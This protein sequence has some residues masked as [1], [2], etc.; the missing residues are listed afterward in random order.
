MKTVISCV[1][2][3]V[4]ASAS[5]GYRA[6]SVESLIKQLKDKDDVVRLKAA[7]ELGKLGAAAKDAIPALTEALKDPDDD[8]R[9]VAKNSLALIREAVEPAE[10]KERKKRAREKLEPLLKDLRG[11]PKDLRRAQT[12][13][14][15]ALKKIA[16]LGADG[17]EASEAIIELCADNVPAIREAAFD[18]LQKVN[19]TLH[20]P[21]IALLIDR[22]DAKKLAAI[23]ELGKL[24]AEAKP[25]IPLLIQFY[26]LRALM[27]RS[28]GFGSY[29]SVP[30]LSALNSIDA[31]NKRF[32]RLLLA[33][34]PVTP[35]SKPGVVFVDWAPRKKAIELTLE[36]VEAKR[37]KARDAVKPFLSA[38]SDP[39]CKIQ[40]IKALGELGVR[41]KDAIPVLTKLKLDPDS[42][43]REAAAE[44]LKK[45][46]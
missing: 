31:E 6:P 5:F 12:M 37:I 1:S 19:P 28:T 43:T 15:S 18:A 35:S 40:A 11:A 3:L 21:I 16:E 39:S 29:F 22:D 45:I 2:V 9:S 42:T 14:L 7:K 36:A 23:A 17:M 30:I 44:A 38:M 26:Q 25:A 46:K 41:A 33:V 13:R 8:V 34:I 4:V 27:A 10:K 24:G 32:H 20:K